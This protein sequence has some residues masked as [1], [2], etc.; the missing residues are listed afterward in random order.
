MKNYQPDFYPHLIFRTSPQ[1]WKLIDMCEHFVSHKNFD[2]EKFE[3]TE[4]G[5]ELNNYYPT[6]DTHKKIYSK[7]EP[8]IKG[9]C[10]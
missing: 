4:E 1:L 3:K 8:I 9:Y 6:Q 7:L 10:S 5:L 2:V